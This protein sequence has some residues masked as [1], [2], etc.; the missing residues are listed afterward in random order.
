[1]SNVS[2]Y[3]RDS[4]YDLE[5]PSF[6]LLGIGVLEDPAT[7]SRVVGAARYIHIDER[8]QVWMM[9]GWHGTL[10]LVSPIH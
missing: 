5:H 1:M 8:G 2:L 6:A 10:R 3:G 7:L 9:T 4:G